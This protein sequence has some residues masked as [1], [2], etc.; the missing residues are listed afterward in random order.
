MLK[1]IFLII[2]LIALFGTFLTLHKSYQ[3]D[4]MYQVYKKYLP[5]IILDC[6]LVPDHITKYTLQIDITN[7]HQVV[8]DLLDFAKK[9][10]TVRGQ[11]LAHEMEFYFRKLGMRGPA[12]RSFYSDKGGCFAYAPRK[13]HTHFTFRLP[14]WQ[15]GLKKDITKVLEAEKK[16]LEEIIKV[17]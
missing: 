13:Y 16:G 3:L 10:R 7:V 9:I 8:N 5:E 11:P 2:I 1:K 15:R 4:P 6:N 14:R 17:F 12:V